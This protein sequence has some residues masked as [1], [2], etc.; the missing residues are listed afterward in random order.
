MDA[1]YVRV[2]LS[3]PAGIL[4]MPAETNTPHTGRPCEKTL[5]ED[6][7]DHGVDLMLIFPRFFLKII[8]IY[9]PMSTIKIG[10]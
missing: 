7:S 3:R 2:A 9:T 4:P 6:H 5:Q 10:Y 8:R 1:K